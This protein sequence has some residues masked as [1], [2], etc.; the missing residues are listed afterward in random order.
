MLHGA[1]AFRAALRE[2]LDLAREFYEGLLRLRAQRLPIEALDE[3]QLTVVPFRLERQGGESLGNWNRRNAA[4]LQLINARKRVFL[5]S[6][7]L[8]GRDGHVFTLRVCILSFR[9]H[10]PKVVQALE[11]V[12]AAATESVSAGTPR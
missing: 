12:A 10:A 1:G 8:P 7:L 9:T 4:F 5:S 2:K 3:P 11:D 6:T